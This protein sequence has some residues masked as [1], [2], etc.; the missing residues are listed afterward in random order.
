[1]AG[2]FQGNARF[3][4]VRR[5]GAGG[6][7]VVYEALDSERHMRVALKTLPQLRPNSLYLFKNEFRALAGVNHPN[8]VTLFELLNEGDD[9][10]FTMQYVEGVNFLKYVT[11]ESPVGQVAEMAGSTSR[12][13]VTLPWAPEHSTR[14]CD[15]GRLRGALSQVVDGLAALHAEGKMHRDIKPSNV[16]V[17]PHD[18]AMIL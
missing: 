13:T 17:T 4:I 18:Q 3:Q 11:A 7:G 1:M 5:V 8:L 2:D 15:Y 16:L 9:W 14:E 10:F 6:M 12:N